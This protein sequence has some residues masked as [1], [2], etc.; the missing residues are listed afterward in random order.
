MNIQGT[1]LLHIYNNT[2]VRDS[3]PYMHNTVHFKH[4]TNTDQNAL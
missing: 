3:K 4:K 2:Y 1:K